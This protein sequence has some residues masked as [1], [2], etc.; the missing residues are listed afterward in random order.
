MAS[1]VSIVI[2]YYN[3][4]KFEKLIEYNIKIQTYP[5]IKEVIIADDSDLPNQRLELDIPYP[6]VYCLV[7]RMTIGEKRNYLKDRAQSEIIAHMDSDDIYFPQYIQSCVDTMILNDCE[8]TGSSDMLFINPITKKSFRQSCLYN[9]MTNEATS[10]YTKNYAKTHH[11]AKR[12]HSENESFNSEHW[13]ITQTPIDEIMVCIT[14]DDNTISKRMWETDQYQAPLPKHFWRT[15]H[16][17]I[18]SKIFEKEI[19]EARGK[20]S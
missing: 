14:H 10:V 18:L 6:V 17:R 15:Q 12:N 19:K 16:Y 8:V 9:Q 20:S 3:R 13:L 7:K 5:N 1:S 4:K 2:P 11:Y